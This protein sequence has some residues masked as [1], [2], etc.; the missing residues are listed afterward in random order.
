MNNDLESSDSSWGLFLG[1]LG[2]GY[3]NSNTFKFKQKCA[4]F[5][6]NH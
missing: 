1:L 4:L 6:Q 5:F 3:P 2:V